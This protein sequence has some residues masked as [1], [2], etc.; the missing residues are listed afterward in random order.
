MKRQAWI[1]FWLVG[2]IWGSSFLLIRIAVKELRPIEIVFIRTAI[3]A[4]GLNAVIALR[5]VPFP[6][7]WR[8]LRA[9]IIIGLGNVVAP[10]LLITWGEQ[11]VPSSLAAVLQSTAALFTLVI[12]HFAFVDERMNRQKIIGLLV[13]FIGVI[14]L[15]SPELTP[16]KLATGNIV[17]GLAVVVASLFYATFTS[18]SRKIIQG[19]VEPIVMA[20][21][22]MAV[23][24]LATAPLAFF[25][26]SGFTTLISLDGGIIGAA[27]LL[28]VLNTFIAYLFYYSVVRELGA[29]RASMV[30]YIVPPVGL[31]LGALFLQEEVGV[32]LLLGT[33]LIFSGIAIVNVK[34]GQMIRSRLE[35]R[36]EG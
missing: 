24:A 8:T 14:V 6:R 33:A 9:I 12:A 15:F 35:A 26:E 11:Y 32:F 25:S 20:G 4:I 21:G 30:T 13:G 34:L 23:A 16:E 27:V 5:G 1:Y 3:A 31:A 28:G 2:I 7:D 36:A 18:F 17:G 22:T 10:F 19:K 29:A